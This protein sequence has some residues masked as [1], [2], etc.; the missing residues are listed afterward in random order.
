VPAIVGHDKRLVDR[1]MRKRADQT[2][3]IDGPLMYAP[4]WMRRREQP[5]L[6]S[7]PTP[8]AALQGRHLD[9]RRELSGDRAMTPLRRQLALN[10][11]QLPAPPT[12]E[13]LSF[14]S[15]EESPSLV[16]VEESPSLIPMVVRFCAAGGVAA[17]VA[18]GAVTVLSD[19]PLK[20]SADATVGTPSPSS[21]GY[22]G[23]EHSRFG[24][25]TKSSIPHRLVRT[26]APS[27]RAQSDPVP[28]SAAQSPPSQSLALPSTQ[29]RVA[30]TP[31][32]SVQAATV[33]APITVATQSPSA[34]ANGAFVRIDA[35]EITKLI[36]RGE[37]F[38]RN[39]DLAS[40]RLLLQRAAE[41]GSATAAL[42]LGTTFDPF[43]IHRLGAIGVAPNVALAREW[44]EKASMLGS[45]AATQLLA[46]L[47]KVGQ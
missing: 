38:I 29:D 16:P 33:A 12:E 9:V 44:Y 2:N 10:P 21:A 39:G 3:E 27:P 22:S 30:R 37:E 31:E 24:S 40:A 45:S 41:A 25:A 13:S 18:W 46:N 17:L 28:P 19:T 1:M 26:S 32:A 14:I 20:V 42:T 11:Q 47:A 34:R 43:V 23:K 6:P 5:I 4:P 8:T 35:E 15:V 36:N 7:S